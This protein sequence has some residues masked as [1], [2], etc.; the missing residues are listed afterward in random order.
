MDVSLML[1]TSAGLLAAAASGG[2]VM[3]GIRFLG[4]RNPPPWL[5]LAHG[6]LVA[7]ALGLLVFATCAGVV[8]QSAL[9]ALALF[10]VASLAGAIMNLGYA[11]KNRLIPATLLI[12]HA[13][14]AILG[15]GFLM[16]AAFVD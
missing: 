8:P 11:W 6:L 5:G 10:L 1:Q 7:A 13:V 14:L 3:A 12:G 16:I 15:F 9:I 4:K 2:L